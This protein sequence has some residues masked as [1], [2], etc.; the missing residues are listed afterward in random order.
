MCDGRL[1]VV[2]LPHNETPVWAR[3]SGIWRVVGVDRRDH[4]GALI[5]AVLPEP[6]LEQN[7]LALPE[8]TDGTARTSATAQIIES[9]A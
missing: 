4:Y 3:D 2:K 8:P 9:A 7:I 1:D 6:T 5:P